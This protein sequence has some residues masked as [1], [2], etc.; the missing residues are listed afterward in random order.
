MSYSGMYE[1]PLRAERPIGIDNPLVMV[2]PEDIFTSVLI[3][4]A[5]SLFF[6][7]IVYQAGAG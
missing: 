1:E 3:L 7:E 6:G 5:L 4:D 2:V